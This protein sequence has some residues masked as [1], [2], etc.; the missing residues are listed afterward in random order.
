[1]GRTLHKIWWY[2]NH[3]SDWLAFV[4]LGGMAA[5]WLMIKIGDMTSLTYLL[6]RIEPPALKWVW[7]I[8]NSAGIAVF[9]M[10]LKKYYCKEPFFIKYPSA[11]EI[12]E[13]KARTKEANIKFDKAMFADDSE[14]SSRPSAATS[15]RTH[16]AT[17]QLSPHP[18]AP[19]SPCP[20]SSRRVPPGRPC[21]SPWLVPG[22]VQSFASNRSWYSCI[23][24][25]ACLASA[26]VS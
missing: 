20:P 17:N 25:A 2:I 16:I 6:H 9:L 1:M 3:S 19:A 5:G 24:S 26:S 10:H 14:N 4:V 15:R 11:E 18:S 13:M 7:L 22:S 23:L 12:A 21:T 8:F